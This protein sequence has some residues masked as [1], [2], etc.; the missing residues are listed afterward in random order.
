[1][2][3]GFLFYD[4]YSNIAFPLAG[5][6]AF[7]LLWGFFTVPRFIGLFVTWAKMSSTGLFWP[8]FSFPAFQKVFFPLREI[9]SP[10][11]FWCIFLRFFQ[12][13]VWY[14][15][16]I[17][18]PHQDIGIIGRVVSASHISPMTPKR[19]FWPPWDTRHIYTAWWGILET[20]R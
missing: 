4:D 8:S 17:H 1:M 18:L 6:H 19:K 10:F 11:N 14:Q 12:V 5:K 9:E 13:W 2:L 7:S 16:A 3:W 20:D 15:V